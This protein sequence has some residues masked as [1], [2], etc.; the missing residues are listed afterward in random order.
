MKLTT[1]TNLIIR[2]ALIGAAVALTGA[3]AGCATDKS[4][5]KDFIEP[6]DSTRKVNQFITA[7]TSKG[8]REDATL[9]A[10]HFNGT[11]LNSLGKEKLA[12]MIP[13]EPDGDVVVYLNLPAS[14]ASTAARHDD[15]AAYLKGLGVDEKH[16]KIQDGMN[17]DL[18][19][20]SA[21]GLANLSKTET[22]NAGGNSSNSSGYGPPSMESAK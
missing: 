16:V 9:H 1:T 8:A 4:E 12:L 17:T 2:A 15:V 20:P 13:D 5:P 21:S 6:V 22:D 10:V 11:T 3:V 19:S 14:A 7:Q 18:G